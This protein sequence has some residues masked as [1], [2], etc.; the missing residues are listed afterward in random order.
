MIQSKQ[1]VVRRVRETRK[2]IGGKAYT[3][4]SAH[5]GSDPITGRRIDIVRSSRAALMDAI[6]DYYAVLR[7]GVM[8][9]DVD[10]AL[11]PKD[12]AEVRAAREKLGATSIVEAADIVA[13]A[14]EVLADAGLSDVSVLDAVAAFVG[15][16]SGVNRKTLADAFDAYLAT[17]NADQETYRKVIKTRVGRMVV[18]LGAER[19]VSDITPTEAMDWVE[20]SFSGLS[21]KTYNNY[22]GDCRT[23]FNWC[24]KPV[25]AF[26]RENPL[27]TAEMRRVARKMPEFMP[28]EDVK[29]W[30]FILLSSACDEKSKMILWWNALGFFAGARTAEI[31]R[32]KWKDVDLDKRTVLFAEPKGFAHGVPPRFVKLNDAAMAWL[33]AAPPTRR[34][35]DD[36]VFADVDETRSVSNYLAVLAKRNGIVLPKNA[37]RHTFV[38]MHVAAYHDAALTESI[39]GTSATMRRSHYQGLVRE[40]EAKRYFEEIR[41]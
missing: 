14:K 3:Y 17:F 31:H 41:P 38:T 4:Y 25:R 21:E 32:L 10:A 18:E 35:P 2:T 27:A 11:N 28:V 37:A 15:T 5:V 1:E 9:G 36:P 39:V 7:A 6:N 30:F 40:E 23:F 13:R 22:L 26:C 19:L 8:P 12:I 20:R 24:A 34:G 29:K 16:K 33:E